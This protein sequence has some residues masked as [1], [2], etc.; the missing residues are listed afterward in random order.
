MKTTKKKEFIFAFICSQKQ[1]SDYNQVIAIVYWDEFIECVDIEKE[2]VRGTAR[3]SMKAVK[4]SPW[5]RI[6]DSKRADML[7][8]KDNTIKIERDRLADL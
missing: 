6:Y 4:G 2:Q 1:L 7:D 5:L 3:L 8:G